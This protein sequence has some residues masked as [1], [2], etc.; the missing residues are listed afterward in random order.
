MALLMLPLL[1]SSM[2]A[3]LN[4]TDVY[5]VNIVSVTLTDLPSGPR[6]VSVVPV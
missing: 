6:V 3:V 1:G 4:F 5:A 2:S